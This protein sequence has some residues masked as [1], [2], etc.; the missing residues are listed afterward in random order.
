MVD[1]TIMHVLVACISERCTGSQLVSVRVRCE[2]HRECHGYFNATKHPGNC[3]LSGMRNRDEPMETAFCNAVINSKEKNLVRLA[4]SKLQSLISF[5]PFELRPLVFASRLEAVRKALS[6]VHGTFFN[7]KSGGRPVTCRCM[8]PS[9]C[10]GGHAENYRKTCGAPL[11]N[12]EL[13]P[14]L[15]RAIA[16]VTSV[17]DELHMA[18]I[19]STILGVGTASAAFGR[20]PASA[21]VEPAARESLE[22]VQYVEHPDEPVATR[23]PELLVE[24]AEHDWADS[25]AERIRSRPNPASAD[26]GV[27]GE[28]ENILL[29]PYTRAPEA[30][31]IALLEGPELRAIREE[32]HDAGLTC[33]LD[34]SGAKIFVKPHQYSLA[35]NA[36]R[37][38]NAP[39]SSHV[40]IAEQYLPALEAAIATIASRENVRSKQSGMRCLTCI[41]AAPFGMDAT[42]E[43]EHSTEPQ[44]HDDSDP[45]V[46]YFDFDV[47]RRSLVRALRNPS[48]VNQSTTEAHSGVNPRRYV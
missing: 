27:E 21:E 45:E 46:G 5:A 41:A 24:Q 9:R 33:V 4:Q 17:Q 11:A 12:P 22:V 30:F 34:R 48:S 37:S 18:H 32:M 20:A 3:S 36:F 1:E 26:D 23:N 2:G 42:G 8:L 10:Y 19:V 14:L 47:E 31:R 39:R 35:L 6:Q 38:V 16:V 44:G 40:I 13:A 29:L 15:S 7:D 28:T 25:V 43:E